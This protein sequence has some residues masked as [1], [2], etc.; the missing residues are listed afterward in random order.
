MN[1]E[2]LVELD[3]DMDTVW[4]SLLVLNTAMHAI[5]QALPA[6]MSGAVARSMDASI[7]ELPASENPPGD[8]ATQTL[9]GWRNMAALKAGLP[10]RLPGS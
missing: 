10:R 8:L 5:V 4:D 6:D 3:H 1:Q 9:Y 7:D 2:K